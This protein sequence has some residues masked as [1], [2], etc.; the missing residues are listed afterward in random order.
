MIVEDDDSIRETLKVFLE[1]EGY[2]V[3]AAE[4]GQQA[5]QFLATI[6]TPGLILLDLMMPVMDGWQFLET[7]RRSQTEISRVPVVVI[8]AYAEKAQSVGVEAVVKKPVDLDILLNKVKFYC[9]ESRRGNVEV[10]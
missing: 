7:C 5:L 10:A 4:N 3:I 9:G 8:T 6:D 1:Y 2:S